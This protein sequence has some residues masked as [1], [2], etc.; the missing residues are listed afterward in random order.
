M[1]R[2]KENKLSAVDG[3]DDFLKELKEQIRNAQ[4]RA[5][6][7]LHRQSQRIF[8]S[9]MLQQSSESLWSIGKYG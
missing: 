2:G 1:V 3:Y 6:L 5:A 7:F 8:P 9:K 4:V